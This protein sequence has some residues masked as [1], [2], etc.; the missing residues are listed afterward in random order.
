M[1]NQIGKHKQKSKTKIFL[2]AHFF[3]VIATF[4]VRALIWGMN[5]I[6]SKSTSL[7]ED[8]EEDSEIVEEESQ[9]TVSEE[10]QKRYQLVDENIFCHYHPQ[11]AVDISNSYRWIFEKENNHNSSTFCYNEVF[12][13]AF[14]QLLIRLEDY[15]IEFGEEPHFVDLGSG[16]GKTLVVA[17]LLN[18]F[19]RVIGI[20]IVPGLFRKGQD[21]VKK[22]NSYYRTPMDQS[23]IELWLGDGTNMDWSFASLVYIQATNFDEI[24]M[25]RISEMADRLAPGSVVILINNRY[26]Y[27]QCSPFLLIYYV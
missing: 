5:S 4:G 7:I 12:P 16:V 20:E 13:F 22:F 26:G 27:M 19:K 6:S 24:M 23:D 14:L 18:K 2:C 17:S 9:A 15:G 21:I 1:Q 25:N 11:T 3:D 8:E 10:L